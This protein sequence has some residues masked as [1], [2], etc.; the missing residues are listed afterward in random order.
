MSKPTA[1]ANEHEPPP[2]WLLCTGVLLVWIVTALVIHCLADDPGKFGDMFGAVNALFSGLAFAGLIYAI[3]LQ[4]IDI[5]LQRTEL[6]LTRGEIAGQR[7]QLEAQNETL[8]KQSIESTFFQLLR[9]HNEIVAAID[10]RKESTSEVIAVGRDCFKTFH[11]RLAKRWRNRT[12]EDA[13]ATPRERSDKTY[14]HFYEGLESELGHYFRSLYNIVKF[15]DRSAVDDKRFYTNLVRAQLSMYELT[16][17]FYNCLSAKGSEKFK[18]LV[19]KY[20]LLKMVPVKSL[21]EP[22][23]TSLYGPHA[24]SSET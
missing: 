8:R 23:H 4:R 6:A 15:I 21:L 7:E 10:L 9:M 13:G 18:P 19:E 20:G 2:F 22:A 1:P 14:V 3:Y 17:L 12:N 16:L 11:E 5:Q 24:F